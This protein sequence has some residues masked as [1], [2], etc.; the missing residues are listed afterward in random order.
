M[1]LLDRLFSKLHPATVHT[2]PNAGPT[3]PPVRGVA[4]VPANTPPI[5]PSDEDTTR[6]PPVQSR[7]NGLRADVRAVN[8]NMIPSQ[9]RGSTR[10]AVGL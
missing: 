10:S 3:I 7:Y 1:R 9:R 2:A 6:L 8:R 5:P 4:R